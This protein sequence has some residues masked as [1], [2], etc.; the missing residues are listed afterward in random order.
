MSIRSRLSDW[1]RRAPQAQSLSVPSLPAPAPRVQTERRTTSGT[2]W[3]G[4]R[5]ATER[6]PELQGR[7]WP[8]TAREM[9]R[10]DPK[11]YGIN[12]ML[13]QALLSARWE[14]RPGDSSDEAARNAEYVRRALGLEG[15][16]S[17][18]RV[19][20]GGGELV[21]TTFEAELRKLLAYLPVGFRVFEELY[22]V[23]GGAVWLDGWGDTE[24]ES[25][26]EWRRDEAGAL[27]EV[28]QQR[29]AGQR[30]PEPLP[31]GRA[32]ILT[33]DQ[34]G[35]DYTGTGLLRPC[36]FWWKL[37]R[38]VADQVAVGAERWANPTPLG[39]IDREALADKGYSL[40]VLAE[41]RAE[42]EQDLEGYTSN[43][44]SFMVVPAGMTVRAFG[45]GA[46][47]PTGLLSVIE[48]C[49]AQM[50]TAY[51]AQVVSVGVGGDG[52][53][54]VGQVHRDLWRQSVTNILDDAAGAIS[55]TTMA[56][57]LELNFYGKGGMPPSKLP[58]LRHVG[59]EVDGL[60]DA[61]GAVPSL[62]AAQVLTPDD[63]LERRIRRLIGLRDVPGPRRTWEERA[64][65]SSYADDAS[66]GEGRPPLPQGVGL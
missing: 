12:R 3:T 20:R 19:R 10:T 29:V 26:Q 24:P 51:A 27:T 55:G 17:M 8:A 35:D 9:L 42:L 57:L 43:E 64:Q 60:A 25:I 62:V 63:A 6:A 32:L 33:A 49:D 15:R 36:W 53:R 18:L 65:S 21:P 38:H 48:Q 39:E 56:R 23:E 37:K 31:V 5:P 45:E 50:V 59:L 47:D 44:A 30:T 40:D 7:A 66:G 28:I 58:T 54:A 2:P 34:T 4:W 16:A 13:V 61:L 14:V 22:R 52:S 1:L 46:Y 41:M 11:L